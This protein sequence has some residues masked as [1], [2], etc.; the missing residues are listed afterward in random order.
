MYLAADPA[1]RAQ[2]PEDGGAGAIADAWA[3]NEADEGVVKT[4]SEALRALGVAPQR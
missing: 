2:L 3:A 4:A 1:V